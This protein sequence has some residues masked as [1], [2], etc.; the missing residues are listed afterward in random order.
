MIPDMLIDKLIDKL[1]KLDGK[2]KELQLFTSGEAT[3][4][5]NEYIRFGTIQE[6]WEKNC[7]TVLSNV[8]NVLFSIMTTVNLTSVVSYDD[9]VRYILK[10]RSKYINDVDFNKVQFMTNY[11]RYPEFLSIQNLDDETKGTFEKNINN[12]INSSKNSN[13]ESDTFLT[14]EQTN[15]LERLVEY[16]N[17]TPVSEKLNQNRKDFYLFTV[18]YDKR[19]KLNFKEIF[20]QLTKFYKLCQNQIQ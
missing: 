4:K 6:K 3:G 17:V 1:N 16:M 2:V 19:R 12:L 18:E 7:E 9:F 14:E 11:L 5:H 15:Q 8:K 10:L 13:W 20:P